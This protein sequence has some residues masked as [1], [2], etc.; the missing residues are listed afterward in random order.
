MTKPVN[1]SILL[2][3]VNRIRTAMLIGEGKLTELPQGEMGQ[4]DRCVIARALSNGW[5]PS[6]DEETI[7]LN[8]D[9]TDEITEEITED[10][11]KSMCSALRASGFTHVNY[12]YDAPGTYYGGNIQINFTPTTTMGNFIER[13]DN[14]EFPH[15]ILN[16]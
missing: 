13:F 5:C 12:E 16:D 6:V 8:H 2:D 9:F 4:S 11:I 1:F 3:Q 10:N 14:G 15:L 7:Y